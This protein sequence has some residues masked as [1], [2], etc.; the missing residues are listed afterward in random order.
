M[1]FEEKKKKKKNRK[2]FKKAEKS[3]GAVLVMDKAALLTGVEKQQ[4]LK[5]KLVSTCLN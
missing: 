2:T 1:S 4:P 5:K 3:T